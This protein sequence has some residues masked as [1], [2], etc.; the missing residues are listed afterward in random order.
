MILRPQVRREKRLLNTIVTLVT[1][2]PAGLAAVNNLKHSWNTGI[3]TASLTDDV[4]TVIRNFDGIFSYYYSK[5]VSKQLPK[6]DTYTLYGRSEQIPNPDSRVSLSPGDRDALGIPRLRMNWA[7]DALDLHSMRQTAVAIGEEAARTGIGRVRVADWLQEG[8]ER[9]SG[10]VGGGHHH[11]G[12]TRMSADPKS[13]V[14]DADCRV[15]GV[16]NL[17]IGGSSVFATG[18]FANPTHTLVALALRLGDTIKG[19]LA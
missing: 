1:E 19:V 7:V 13:G 6:T 3:R 11:M 15:H 4:L 5:K 2:P 18:G 12:T 16:N 17:F 9:P 8:A 10:V 14:V